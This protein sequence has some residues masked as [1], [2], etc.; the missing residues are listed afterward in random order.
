MKE[1][2]TEKLESYLVIRPELIDLNRHL[3]DTFTTPDAALG[4]MQTPN[5]YLLHHRK[6]I[7]DN[8]APVDFV[9]MRRINPIRATLE[10]IDSGIFG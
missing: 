3:L 1:N 8:W 6:S 9:R 7:L 5:D 4:W 10:A 2:P